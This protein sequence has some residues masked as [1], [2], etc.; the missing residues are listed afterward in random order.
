MTFFLSVM[1]EQ[2]IPSHYIPLTPGVRLAGRRRTT[3]L[4]FQHLTDLSIT[5]VVIGSVRFYE[6]N[7]SKFNRRIQPRYHKKMKYLAAYLLLNAA[8]A[9]PSAEKVKAVLS[10]VGIEPEEEKVGALLTSLEGKNVDELI[11]EGNE[12]LSSIPS[13][14]PAPAAGAA[15]G[16]E[17]PKE[18]AKEE[19]AEES[20]DEMGFGLFD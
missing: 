1:E 4:K 10:S 18:E 5:I 11:A 6:D 2:Q 8:G 16:D 7:S 9:E 3:Q 17:A 15:G 20:D 14:G 13:A 19:A 12:K